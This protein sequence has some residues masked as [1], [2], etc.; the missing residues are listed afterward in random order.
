MLRRKIPGIHAYQRF[1][2]KIKSGQAKERNIIHLPISIHFGK[3]YMPFLMEHDTRSM[4][5]HGILKI[6]R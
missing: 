4:A 5:K 3:E 1:I 6:F 2:L